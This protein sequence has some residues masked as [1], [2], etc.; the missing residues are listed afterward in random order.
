MD[1]GTPGF[2]V[3]HHLLKFAQ[4]HVHWV[5]DAIQLSH[6]LLPP[7]SSCHQSFQASGSFPMS[8]FFQW[9]KY[10]SF[11]FSIGPSYE[12]SGLIAFRVVSIDL[13]YLC[14][15]CRLIKVHLQ[16][17]CF[18]PQFSPSFSCIFVFTIKSGAKS[19]HMGFPGGS[20]VKKY[21][22]Q[23]RKHRRLVF[24]PWV[25]KIPWRRKWWPIILF[26]PGESHGLRRIVVYSP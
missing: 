8:Q 22:C 5:G 14:F 16:S 21:A 2:P 6:P 12:Y 7:F 11:S 23:C 20:L 17:M 26:L 10:W 15:H 25:G 19:K 1:C 18:L 4:T 3:L 24:S 9:S 13:V